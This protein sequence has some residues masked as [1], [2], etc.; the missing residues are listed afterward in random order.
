[1]EAAHN[2]TEKG[3]LLPQQQAQLR[4]QRRQVSPCRLFAAA[5]AAAA[6][7]YL[8]LPQFIS[9][10]SAGTCAHHSLSHASKVAKVQ[11]CAIDNLKADT[12]FLDNAVPIQAEEFIQ[13]RDRLANALVIDGVDAFV[14][15]PGYTFQYVNCSQ[16]PRS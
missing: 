8:F 16:I 9:I 15:E 13:R 11:Q 14:V 4:L 1:M 2:D 3:Q 5:A 12:W 10:L 7:I 6:A